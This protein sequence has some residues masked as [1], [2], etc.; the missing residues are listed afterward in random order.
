MPLNKETKP[1]FLSP[2]SHSLTFLPNIPSSLSL[3]LFSFLVPIFSLHLLFLLYLSWHFLFLSL[4]LSL[5]SL[6]L[7]IYIYISACCFSLL[8]IS[9]PPPFFCF[10]FL[11]LLLH[12]LFLLLFSSFSSFLLLPIFPYTPRFISSFLFPKFSSSLFS[13]LFL[14]FLGHFSPTSSFH[15]L[16][17]SFSCFLL[18]LTLPVSF[19]T[20]SPLYSALFFSSTPFFFLSFPYPFFI[21]NSLHFHFYNCFLFPNSP[22]SSFL[23]FYF[24]LPSPLLR[25]LLIFFYLLLLPPTSN[26]SVSF[27]YSI[28]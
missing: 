20:F 21:L 8:L 13:P 4:S 25:H 7:Y 15:L 19:L 24:S 27:F 23:L 22:C 2:L 5:N 11:Q 18:P 6:S 9:D 17:L 14:L 26:P 16:F 3:F 1:F 12:L 28:I 10:L